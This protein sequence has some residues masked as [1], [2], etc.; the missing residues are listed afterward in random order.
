MRQIFET[1][2]PAETEALGARLASSLA[3]H[4]PQ[5]A[6][7]AMEGEMGV[8]KT[9]FVR[10]FTEALGFRGAKSPTYTIVN[11]YPTKIPVF[12][13]DMYRIEEPDDLYAIGFED[14]LA[15]DGYL[16]L[17]WS[18]NVKEALF[19]P[20]I[21]VC[22]ERTDDADGRRITVLGYDEALR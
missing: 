9:A 14:Y 7:I 17:E 8:G 22:I 6:L 16:L 15:K 10:G 13:F 20:H 1:N 2:S 12:H 19:Q 11:E 4:L 5:G 18:E 3:R 21:T